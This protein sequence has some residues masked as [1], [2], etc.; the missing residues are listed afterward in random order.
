ML[1]SMSLNT[2][3]KYNTNYPPCRIQYGRTDKNPKYA[4]KIIWS[5]DSETIYDSENPLPCG[6]QIWIEIKEKPKLIGEVQ[7]SEIRNLM[8]ANR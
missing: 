1:I 3:K 2:T 5:G 4:Q 8:I 7:Y 6:A